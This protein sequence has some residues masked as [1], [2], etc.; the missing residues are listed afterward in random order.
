MLTLALC[1][2]A[3]RRTAQ[4]GDRVL[5]ITSRALQQSGGYPEAAVI[6]C[7]TVS[8]AVEARAYYARRSSFRAR[9]DY[10]YHFRPATGEF[11]HT[12]KTALH[13]TPESVRKDLGGFPVY[14]NGRVLICDEFRYFGSG[15]IPIPESMPRLLG[16]AAA[17][18]QGHRVFHGGAD[19]AIDR[20]LDRLFRAL[21]RQ[22]TRFTPRKVEADLYERRAFGREKGK[23]PAP[24]S[25][26]DATAALF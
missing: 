26:A 9:P 21:G 12:G 5:A 20:E 14:R 11:R 2:P 8:E 15:A 23:A 16:I 24:I 17:L 3:I 1:K 7:A 4:V 10:V 19:P 18:G 25:H 6:Y 13:A 22:V